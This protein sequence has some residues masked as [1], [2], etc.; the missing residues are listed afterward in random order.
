VQLQHLLPIFATIPLLTHC[1]RLLLLAADH[2]VLGQQMVHVG[3]SLP[4][5]PMRDAA[6]AACRCSFTAKESACLYYEH[7]QQLLLL[8]LLL[9][10]VLLRCHV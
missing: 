4:P 1:F 8:L 10:L 9:L 2:P 6:A 7:L 3:P 5:L